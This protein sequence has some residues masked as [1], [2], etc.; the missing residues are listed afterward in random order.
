MSGY[1]IE[2]QNSKDGKSSV[3]T[4]IMKAEEA[5]AFIEKRTEMKLKVLDYA[6]L[7]VDGAITIT[8]IPDENFAGI[9]ADKEIA[10][11]SAEILKSEIEP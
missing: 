2:L 4:K 8:S 1:L 6:N 3:R 5:M 7:V 10:S 11:V 9:E